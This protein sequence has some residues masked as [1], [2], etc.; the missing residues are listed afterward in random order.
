MTNSKIIGKLAQPKL[1]LF[2][3]HLCSNLA[4]GDKHPLDNTDHLWQKCI[5]LGKQLQTEPKLDFLTAKLSQN[6]TQNN[7]QRDYLE[8]WQPDKFIP[9]QVTSQPDQIPLKGVI[10][11]LQLHDTYAL[12]FTLLAPNDIEIAQLNNLNFQSCLL[13]A[14]IQ[15]SLGQTLLLFAQPNISSKLPDLAT[16][17]VDALF[18]DAKA[19]QPKPYLIGKGI[20][21]G[22]PIFEFDNDQEDPQ[23]KCHIL[24]WFNSHEKT[25]ELEETGNYYRPLINLLCCRSKILYAYHQA[26]QCNEEARKLYSQL[27]EKVEKFN[28]LESDRDKRLTELEKLLI[29]IP[30]ISLSYSRYLR[31]MKIHLIT[32]QTNIFNY[33]YQ[34]EQLWQQSLEDLDKLDFLQDFSKHRCQIFQ[35]QIKVNRS[36]LSA[37]QQLFQQM[38]ETIRGIVEIDAQKQQEKSEKK[39]KKRDRKLQKTVAVVGVGIG[40]SGVA[41]TA[42]PYIFATK[43]DQEFTLMPVRF[44]SNLELNPFHHLTL[45]LLFSLSAGLLGVAIAARAIKHMQDRRKGKIATIF[46]FIL[47]RFPEQKTSQPSLGSESDRSQI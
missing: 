35:R 25:A 39:E 43:P 30:Q 28:S 1:T 46:R 2:A 10:Y 17:C 22:S 23:L 19:N 13:P 5:D 38:I 37:G 32:I 29:E 36:Y 7:S 9:F 8:L 11:P 21:L 4:K 42:S 6:N 18:S 33:D 31:D 16:A 27:E 15:A 45:S 3:F 12:D 14:N 34:L 24:V 44:Q 26:D 47:G 20:L 41:A 40:A